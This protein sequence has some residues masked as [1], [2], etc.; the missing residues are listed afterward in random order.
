M[1]LALPFAIF[2][3][4]AAAGAFFAAALSALLFSR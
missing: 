4:S 2:S 3:P 1:F